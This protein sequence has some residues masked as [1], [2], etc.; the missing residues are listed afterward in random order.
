MPEAEKETIQKDNLR[1]ARRADPYHKDLMRGILD[2]RHAY[3]GPKIVQIDITNNCNLNCLYCWA[4]SPL[5]RE[6]QANKEWESYELPLDLI[7]KLIDDLYLLGTED[8]YIA[9]GGEP[10]MH[11]NIIDILKYIKHKGMRCEVTTNFTLITEDIVKRIVELG[12]DFVTVSL[13]AGTAETY[14]KL[15]LNAKKETFFQ[16]IE[17]ALIRS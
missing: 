2:G 12:V 9:G 4:R 17:I 5:L 1:I 15:H 14:E 13:W 10:F 6:K 8:I 3:I 11:P 16:I 7:K